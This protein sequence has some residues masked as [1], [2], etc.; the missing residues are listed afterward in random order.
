MTD[1]VRS[2]SARR[3]VVNVSELTAPGARFVDL[4]EGVDRL[5]FSALP[6][7]AIERLVRK[8]RLSRYRAALEAVSAAQ[9]MPII[10]HLP[11][12]TAAVSLAQFLTAHR[13]P[14]LAFSFNFTD[15]PQG[16]SR[17]YLARMFRA[18]DEFFVFSDFE[19]ELYPR[20]FG[21]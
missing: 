6:Q 10:S 12:M 13:S 11:R 19:R 16:M 20:F 3:W 4:P 8:P 15:L 14:H 5:D 21:L 7:T 9:G 2:A 1:L 18:V 17:S